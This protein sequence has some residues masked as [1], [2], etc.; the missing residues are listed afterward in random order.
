[1]LRLAG[2]KAIQRSAH[3]EAITHFSAALDLL[4]TL[5]ETAEI[6]QEE[7]GLQ[8][9]LGLAFTPI[10]GWTAPEVDTAYARA[11]KLSHNRADTA[12]LFPALWGLWLICLAGGNRTAADELAEQLSTLAQRLDDPI[13]AAVA[14]Y[15]VA[16]NLF[17]AGEFASA[18]QQLER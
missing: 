6:V 12:D 3:G 5:P 10:K 11:R 9:A 7:L 8:I 17:T 14:H 15:T 2:Q 16:S 18:C 1:Y 4:K 13:L